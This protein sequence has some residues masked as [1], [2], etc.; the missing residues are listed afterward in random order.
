MKKRACFKV[1]LC[2]NYMIYVYKYTYHLP[3][4]P[5]AQLNLN[6]TVRKFAK[7]PK[8]QLPHPIRGHSIEFQSK[9]INLLLLFF[10]RLHFNFFPMKLRWKEFCLLFAANLYDNCARMRESH[11]LFCYSQMIWRMFSIC[12]IQL[13]ST[14]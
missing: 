5:P 11:C 12:R 13:N 1:T 10:F 2:V 7:L 8:K 9:V 14:V 4:C 3:A 6:T